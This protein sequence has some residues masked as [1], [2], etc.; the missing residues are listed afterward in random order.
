MASF[1]VNPASPEASK[2]SWLRK[3]CPS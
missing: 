1:G 2:S 3:T